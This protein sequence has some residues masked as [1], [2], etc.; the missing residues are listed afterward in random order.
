MIKNRIIMIAGA[1]RRICGGVLLLALGAL[2]LARLEDK[3]ASSNA[4]SRLASAAAFAERG[5]WALDNSP[6]L[7]SHDK[8]FRGGH[9]YSSKP[10]AFD[11]LAAGV[12]MAAGKCGCAFGAHPVAVYRILIFLLSFL[13][14]LGVVALTWRLAASEPH[15]WMAPTAAGCASLLWPYATTLTNHPLTA[16]LVLTALALSRRPCGTFRSALLLGCVAASAVLFEVSIGVLWPLAIGV[17]LGVRGRRLRIAD[18]GLLIEAK[19]DL[20]R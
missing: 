1:G 2:T 13:P 9:F 4:A 17:L 8:I 5:A 15:G 20:Y 18:C 10:P 14:F 7:W 6:F 19:H 16:L 12:I 11:W 3:P